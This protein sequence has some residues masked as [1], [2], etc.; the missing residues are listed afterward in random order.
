MLVTICR[1]LISKLSKSSHTC[2]VTF[3]EMS[4]KKMSESITRYLVSGNGNMVLMGRTFFH[5]IH[6][7]YRPS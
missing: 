3:F 5:T 1:L 2:L 7:V 6:D 4:I